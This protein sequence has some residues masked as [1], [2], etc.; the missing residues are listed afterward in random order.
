MKE[1]IVKVALESY[2]KKEYYD[3]Y[4][5][6]YAYKCTYERTEDYTEI[7]RFKTLEEAK[8]FVDNYELNIYIESKYITIEYIVIYEYDI[9]K[10]ETIDEILYDK[11]L[12]YSD[13]EK[14]TN[15]KYYFE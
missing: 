10:E 12:A 3:N 11:E 6:D 14:Y 13:I 9:E 5:E 7:K 4:I 2:K 15:E 1:Y 8:K